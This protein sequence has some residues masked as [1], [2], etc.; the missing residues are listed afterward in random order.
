MATITGSYPPMT[1]QDIEALESRKQLSLPDTYK[2]F[3]LR[4]N[5]GRPMPDGFEVPGWPGR[6]SSVGDFYGIHP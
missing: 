1:L 2:A 6:S 5:G 3:L 4:S